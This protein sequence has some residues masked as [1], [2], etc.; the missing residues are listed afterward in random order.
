MLQLGVNRMH[1]N[2]NDL[3]YVQ[4]KQAPTSRRHKY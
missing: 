4:C 1:V 3:K 2:M